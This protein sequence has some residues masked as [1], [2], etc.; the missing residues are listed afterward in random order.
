MIKV[1]FVCLGNICRSPMAEAVFQE[2]VNQAGL[3]DRI[4]VDSAGTSGWHEGEKAHSGTLDILKRNNIQYN[5]RSR[6]LNRRDLDDFDY[7]VTM[8]KSN[9]DNIR[10]MAGITHP[11]VTMFLSYANRAGHTPVEEVPD[12]YYDGGF[13]EVYQLVKVGCQALL[14]HIR[15]EQYL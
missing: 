13:Y 3:D 6:Q 2:L 4:M 11:K 8:D 10:Q 5:G 7:I 14:D 1:L 9:F 15:Q 12:P